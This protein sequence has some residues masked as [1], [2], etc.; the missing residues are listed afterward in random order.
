MDSA[1]RS[2][3]QAATLS[4]EFKKVAQPNL[5]NFY[6]PGKVFRTPWYEPADTSQNSGRDPILISGRFKDLLAEKIQWFIV[7]NSLPGHCHCVRVTTHNSRATTKPGVNPSHYCVLVPRGVSPKLLKDE[8]VPNP[9]IHVKLF[10]HTQEIATEA[11]VDLGR[12]YTVE[13]NVAVDPIGIVVPDDLRIMKSLVNKIALK[14]DTDNAL[15][16]QHEATA[17]IEADPATIY[18]GTSTMNVDVIAINGLS[19]WH[20]EFVEWLSPTDFP[21]QQHDIFSRRTDGTAEWFRTSLEFKNWQNGANEVLFC[22]GIPGAGKTVISAVVIDIL[23]QSSNVDDVGI[24]CLFCNYKAQVEQ[25][26]PKLIAALLKQLVQSRPQIEGP[27]MNAYRDH[28]KRGTRPFLNELMEALRST[29]SKYSIVYM[30]IDAL[31]ECSN[32][33]SVSEACQLISILRNLQAEADVRL[34]FT[35]RPL[36]AITQDFRLT[37]QLEIRASRE[38]VERFVVSQMPKLPGCIQHNEELKNEV[39]THIVEAVDGMFL[40]ARLYVDSFLDTTTP[41]KVRANLLKLKESSEILEQAYK[42]V[43]DRIN[44][45]WPGHQ[46]LAK[47][48]LYWIMC[49]Q[50]VLTTTELCQALAIESGESALDHENIDCSEDIV[51][52][53]AGLIAIDHENSEVRF[54]HSTVREFL[55]CKISH[56]ITSAQEEVAVGCLTYLSFSTFKDG[57]CPSDETLEQRLAENQFLNYCARYWSHHVRPVQSSVSKLA[58]GFLCDNGLVDS[59]IQAALTTDYQVSGY[60]RLFPRQTSGLHLAA[61]YDLPYLTE[62][63]LAIKIGRLNTEVN[64]EDSE[65]RTPLHYAAEYGHGMV[66]KLLLDMGAD[67]NAQGGWYGHALQAA[68]VHGHE[69]VVKRLIVMG[70]DVNAQGGWYGNALQGASEC[71]HTELVKLLRDHGANFNGQDGRYGKVLQAAASH[72]QEEVMKLLLNRYADVNARSGRHDNALDTVN[73]QGYLYADEG[74]LAEAEVMYTQALRAFEDLLGANNISTL[75]IVNNLGSL[76]R[77]QG[78]LA[79]AE[80]MYR[81][82]LQGK[83]ETFGLEDPTT[84]STMISLGS[85]YRYQGKR[86]MV[87]KLYTRA[88]QGDQPFGVSHPSTI[89][90]IQN[91]GNRFRDQSRLA[92]AEEAYRL[93][94]QGMRETLGPKHPST[95]DTIKNLGNIFRDQSRL[96]EA[97]EMYGLALHG[98]KEAR[99]MKHA[100]TTDTI[101]NLI[102]LHKRPRRIGWGRADI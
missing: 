100:V 35:S 66:V 68:V 83:E 8:H 74:R 78:K 96:A 9:P 32:S 1:K 19:R 5:R 44:G 14:N 86:A 85:I 21:A 88:L 40:L 20:Q 54:V 28:L 55:E 18:T 98:K 24:A 80:Q 47:R 64:L 56:W 73:S 75:L 49:A 22:P 61:R 77:D 41:K 36:P 37:P 92:E 25:S 23:Y 95:I 27:L 71:R 10:E 84:I 76:Y 3:N 89:G 30:V 12:I 99:G 79:E 65:H 26:V 39:Q 57:S 33:N 87:G 2:T 11:R 62:M 69:M 43:D 97:E 72:G 17:A 70:A 53:C 102:N 48:A 63:L 58:L 82:A 91:L 15:P 94:L 45:Q 50:R 42:D 4:S 38:D 29:C 101:E 13:Y 51:A 67:V 81:R 34:L 90:T 59:V 31:D 52:V 6:K 46:I 93:A 16:P 60:S 7:F